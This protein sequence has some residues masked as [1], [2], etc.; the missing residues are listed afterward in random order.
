MYKKRENFI[1]ITF[2]I[3]YLVPEN[4][5]KTSFSQ[6]IESHAGLCYS[7]IRPKR[8]IYVELGYL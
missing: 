7:N 3:P 6:I 5:L 4:F 8:S 1:K 2:W